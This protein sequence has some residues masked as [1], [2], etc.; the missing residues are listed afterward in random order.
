MALGKNKRVQVKLKT[1]TF[2]ITSED[3]DP[4]SEDTTLVFFT[5]AEPKYATVDFVLLMGG[6]ILEGLPEAAISNFIYAASTALD[7]MLLFNPD[8]KFP[9]QSGEA[10]DFFQR[11]RME[12]VSCKAIRDVLRAALATR[13]LS[14]G[15]RT[16]ADFTIDLSSQANLISQA[17]QF[18]ND[19]AQ[20]CKFWLSAIFSGG[21]RDHQFPDPKSVVKSGTN[22]FEQ[23]GI[24][25]G[26]ISG[27]PTLNAREG[28]V[29]ITSEGNKS[30]PQRFFNPCGG[31]SR[32]SF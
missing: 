12:F 25:R 23:A 32:G 29:I 14:A 17:R 18:A 7:A 2:Q 27:G 16:L 6:D 26:W 10:W 28:Q 5:L 15:R 13:G 8:S 20:N 4:L 19:M 21:A 24:G 30:K 31:G 22:Q 1:N 9:T 3:G 11:A